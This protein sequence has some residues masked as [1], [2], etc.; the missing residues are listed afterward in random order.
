MENVPIFD[1][2]RNPLNLERGQR[3]RCKFTMNYRN[4]SFPAGTIATFMGYELRHSKISPVKPYWE[5]CLMRS[6]CFR[7]DGD[8]K[9][10]R[11]ISTEELGEEV[12]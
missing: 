1:V 10:D 5:P 2:R 6:A 9:D 3:F 11:F 12:V 4:K 8:S 7:F